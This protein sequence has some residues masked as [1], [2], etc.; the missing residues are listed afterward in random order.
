M[1]TSL[2]FTTRL[3]AFLLVILCTLPAFAQDEDKLKLRSE[4]GIRQ[5]L[6]ERKMLELES[7]L[8][9]IAE[10]L[11]EKE[12][13]R[14]KLLVDAFQK[15]KEQLITK[16]MA[17][18]GDLLDKNQLP[19]ADKL[20]DEVIQNLESLIRLLTD[21][22]D[23]ELS[24]K[25]EIAQLDRWKK[26]IE[27]RLKEQREQTD[28]TEKVANKDDTVANLEA[29]IKALEN[30]I[31]KQRDVIKETEQKSGEGLRALDKVADKQFEVRKGTEELKKSI[32]GENI[33]P[34]SDSK[35]GEQKPGESKPG[36]SKPG[37]SKPGESKP[38]E[39]KPGESKPG[40]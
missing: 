22:K 12:P 26:A 17:M 31:G 11:Q 28:D 37:E 29:Q 15:S 14:A 30:L 32:A 40:E 25:D 20:T 7:K 6:V 34:G 9:V 3:L 16:K 5:R 36:E 39:S 8:T 4:L 27:E 18:I 13:A 24:K 1:N 33:K 2:R 10:K 23:Q 21:Q 19:E 38:G 35:P